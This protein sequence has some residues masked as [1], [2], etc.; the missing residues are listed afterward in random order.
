MAKANYEKMIY[1]MM[2]DLEKKKLNS[3]RKVLCKYEI[4]KWRYSLLRPAEDSVC[5]DFKGKWVVYYFERG[6]KADIKS[7]SGAAAACNDV[8]KRLAPNNFTRKRMMHSFAREIN[9]DADYD[10]SRVKTAFSKAMSLT[11]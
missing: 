10:S 9:G 6:Q 4:P 1:T 8:I 7:Y 2:Q 3:L 5:L 11:L